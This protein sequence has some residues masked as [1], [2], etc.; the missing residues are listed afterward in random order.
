ME[1]EQAV[2]KFCLAMLDNVGFFMEFLGCILVKDCVW[3]ILQFFCG[4]I[5][6]GFLGFCFTKIENGSMM[7]LFEV[8]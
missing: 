8:K 5:I 4:E 1:H 2:P 3:A 7:E 6:G